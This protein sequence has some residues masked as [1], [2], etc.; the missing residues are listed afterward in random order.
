MGLFFDS[1]YRMWHT[2]DFVKI[3]KCVFFKWI[4]GVQLSNLR[5]KKNHAD[6]T[7]QT[8]FLNFLEGAWEYAFLVHM[9]FVVLKRAYDQVPR[10]ILWVI[11]QE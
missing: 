9:C 8:S 5:Q 2:G 7:K 1:D 6:F 11:L 10:G 4:S 3:G